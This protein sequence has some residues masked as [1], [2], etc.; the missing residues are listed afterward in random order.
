MKECPNTP[1]GEDAELAAGRQPAAHPRV[2]GPPDTWSCFAA[3][4]SGRCGSRTGRFLVAV[5]QAALRH[6]GACWFTHL[7]LVLVCLG[8]TATTIKFSTARDDLVSSDSPYRRRFLEFKTEF[9]LLDNLFVLVESESREKNRAFVERLG[10]RLERSPLFSNVYYRGKLE[11]LGPKA[12]QFLPEDALVALQQ[13]VRTNLLVFRMVSEAT[14]LE[15]LIAVVTRQ[16]RSLARAPSPA[17][18][19]GTAAQSLTLVRQVIDQAVDFLESPGALLAIDSAL[20]LDSP[21]GDLRHELY[22]SFDRGRVYV[23][24]AR[25]SRADQEPAAVAQLRSWIAETRAEVSGVNVALTGEAVLRGDEMEQARRDTRLASWLALAL[26]ALLLVVA[27]RG[28]VRP[29][30]AT[31]CLLIGIAY[32]LGFATLTVGRLNL[33]SITLVPVLIGLSIDYGVHLMFRFEEQRGTGESSARAV[34]SALGFTGVGIFVSAVT[35]AAV[36]YALLLTDFRGIAEMGLIAGTGLVLGLVPMLTLLPLW[37]VRATPAVPKRE[38][39]AGE[40]VRRGRVTWEELCLRRSGLLLAAG[41]VVSGFAALHA[42]RVEFD[43]NLLNLQS[44]GLPAVRLQQ[45]LREA[46]SHSLLYCA[47][48]ADSLAQAMDWEQRILQLGS[49]ARV[50]SLVKYMTEDQERKLAAIEAIREDLAGIPLPP[51]DPRAVNL[52]NLTSALSALRAYL[53]LAS[54]VW[55]Q[56]GGDPA[57]EARLRSLRDSVTRL[58]WLL[59][60]P[61]S[62]VA[63][64]L[65]TLQEALFGRWREALALMRQP[66]DGRTLRAEDVPAFVR[67]VFLSRSGHFLLQVYPKEDVWQRDN[68]QQFIRELRSVDP[69]VTGSPVQFYEYTTSLKRNVEKAAG[70]AMG[71]VLGLLLLHFRRLSFVLLALLPVLLGYLWMLGIMGWLGL[72]FNPVN[73]M[74]VIL[75]MGIGVTNGIHILNRFAEEPRPH[76]VTKS[77]GKGVIVSALSTMAG[78]GSLMVAGHQGI[79][80]LGAVMA[81]GTGT[82]LLASLVLL[83]AVLR[84]LGQMGWQPRERK[85]RP[86]ARRG[87]GPAGG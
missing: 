32:T 10:E 20:L 58:R 76:L 42:F 21:A 80:S 38:A 45:R 43:Y 26:T 86:G 23:V 7:L 2:R 9:R 57:A 85:H 27:F 31:L 59:A 78:F 36:F 73:I 3:S 50:I 11:R 40:V 8:Y 54:D 64:R 47:V 51:L 29:L 12:L 37:L 18:Q 22:L 72:S 69:E 56:R 66:N 60:G 48:V 68:Q 84:V 30:L 41:A 63:G 28:V 75:V 33:V 13:R 5:A 79:A 52:T 1:E 82:C 6:P 61:E 16:V 62:S 17:A 4:A 77:T 81:I 65:T 34:G 70:Y 14:N 53:G 74:S 44:R 39:G 19:S 55:R 25:P 46:G 15:A 67:D 71:I 49:V 87:E 35:L 83:P 24:V